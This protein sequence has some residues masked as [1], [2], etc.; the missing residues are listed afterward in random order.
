MSIDEIY[1][2]KGD[3]F[4]LDFCDSVDS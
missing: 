3:T 4:R 2:S 1:Q